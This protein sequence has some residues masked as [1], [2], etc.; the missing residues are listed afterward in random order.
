MASQSKRITPIDWLETL[1]KSIAEEARS[2]FP[3]IADCYRNLLVRDM[4][5]R[6]APRE[7][8]RLL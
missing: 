1:P 2:L 3:G 4:P 5:Q 6:S 7:V 8:F